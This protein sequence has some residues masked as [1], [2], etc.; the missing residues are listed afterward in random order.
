MRL[1]IVTLLFAAMGVSFGKDVSP[2]SFEKFMIRP[3]AP[4]VERRFL[5]VVIMREAA[6][7]HALGPILEDACTK[8]TIEFA[9]PD[10]DSYPRVDAVA[11]D[12]SRHTL[13]FRRQLLGWVGHGVKSWAKSYWPYYKNEDMRALLPVI[14]IIDD[15]LWMT[16]L[17]EAAHRKGLPWPHRECSSL[18]MQ[19]RLG[20]EMLVSGVL[21]SRRPAQPMFNANRVDRLWPESL[22]ELR[23]SGWRQ[24]D[25]AYR[26]VQQ[27]GGSM[28]VRPLI[29]EFGVPR[30]LK[31]IAQ[32]PFHIQDD[33]VRASAQHYQEQ[34]RLALTADAI[35]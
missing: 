21:S 13:T 5:E 1:L 35:N 30:V 33:N 8:I 26:D 27:L 23:A 14:E 19:K 20:C 32:T 10:D 7:D 28:L 9:V 17:Q 18:D 2:T 22:R 34:A 12:P 31:Y 4:Q 16:H 15:A 3:R 6:I 25:G 24:G 11:Y 29:A